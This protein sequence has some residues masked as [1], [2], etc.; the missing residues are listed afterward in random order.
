[1]PDLNVSSTPESL[2]QGEI[3]PDQ[4]GAVETQVEVEIPLEQA[5][6]QGAEQA[7]AQAATSSLSAQA[8]PVVA[9]A[10]PATPV[11]E[12]TEEEKAIEGI[13]AEGLDNL[14]SNLPDNRKQEFKQKGEEAA[15]Q[16]NQ[17]LQ[18]VKVKVGKIVSIIKKWLAMIPGVN[19]FFLEQES[20][21][22]ADKLLEYKKDKLVH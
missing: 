9:P 8:A 13:L 10:V 14:Y 17:L 18:A 12:K 22:K 7:G 21:I 11:V 5:P 4:A 6:E 3:K 20:K 15:T 19:K 1:M 16:I 2:P